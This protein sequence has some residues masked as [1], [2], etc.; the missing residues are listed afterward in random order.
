M[1]SYIAN[2]LLWDTSIERAVTPV[3]LR[4]WLV[5]AHRLR[6]LPL[7]TGILSYHNE[8]VNFRGCKIIESVNF[9]N[10]RSNLAK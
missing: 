3:A 7:P 1:S 5:F 2:K 10:L 8:S 9:S 6:V 4:Q